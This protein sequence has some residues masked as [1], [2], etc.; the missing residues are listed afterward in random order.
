M[1]AELSPNTC[2]Q[3]IQDLEYEL[4]EALTLAQQV[5]KRNSELELQLVKSQVLLYEERAAT[6]KHSN[7][8]FQLKDRVNQLK[9]DL[10]TEKKKTRTLETA[11]DKCKYTVKRLEQSESDLKERGENCE[12]TVVMTVDELEECKTSLS[13]CLNRC[14]ERTRI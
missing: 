13:G 10:S 12:E 4:E 7:N 6:Q 1:T 8:E 14:P 9:K 11:H 5:N 2:N 3:T